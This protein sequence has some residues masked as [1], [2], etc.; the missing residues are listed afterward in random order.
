MTSTAVRSTRVFGTFD[1]Q[2]PGNDNV[3]D[4]STHNF[5]QLYREGGGKKGVTYMVNIGWMPGCTDFRTMVADNPQGKSG[6]N[7]DQSISCTDIFKATYDK[8]ELSL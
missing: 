3:V 2:L 6:D 7:P 1:V 4:S 5:T 8:C